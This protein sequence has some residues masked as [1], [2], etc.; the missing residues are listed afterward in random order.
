ML[1]YTIA[2]VCLKHENAAN[3]TK[4]LLKCKSGAS[5]ICVASLLEYLVTG[6]LKVTLLIFQC[7]TVFFNMKFKVV[8]TQL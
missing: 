6:V 5:D 8:R 7:T 1:L 4:V 2:T 3:V